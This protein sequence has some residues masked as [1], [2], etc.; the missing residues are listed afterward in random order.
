MAGEELTGASREAVVARLDLWT[1][2]HLAAVLAPLVALR[3]AEDIEGLARGIAFRLIENF[4]SLNR[5]DVAEDVRALDQA[6]RGQLR[7]YGVRFGG[8]SIF[9]PALLK[10]APARTLLI[11]WAMSRKDVA[12]AFADLPQPPT[13]GLTSVPADPAAPAGFYDALGFRVSGGRAVRLD[14]LERIADLIRPVI[15]ARHYNGGFIVTPAM[16][17]LVGCSGEEFSNLLKVLGYRS[18]VEKIKPPKIEEKPAEPAKFIVETKTSATETPAPASE[19][20]ATTEADAAPVEMPT[21]TPIAETAEA[22]TPAIEAAPEATAQAAEPTAETE[23]AAAPE[24]PT[25]DATAASAA[26]EAVEMVE[27]EI[28]RPQRRNKPDQQGQQQNRPR[29]ARRKPEGATAT[30]TEGQPVTGEAKADDAARR[31]RRD[32]N[33]GKFDKFGKADGTTEARPEG[34]RGEGH[35]GKRRDDRNKGGNRDDRNKGGNKGGERREWS[36]TPPR[37]ER[38]IDPDSP[39]AALAVLKERVEGK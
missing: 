37:R 36:S 16:M 24:A 5:E 23:T 4:G 29:R 8:Y 17:S 28:W 11:L 27:L 9:M 19:P 32:R 14:M 35:K 26:D 10:P 25:E 39:F 15:T 2:A 7:K 1:K 22:E 34:K 18:R 13:A 20:A 6:A 33:K 12:D 21:E 38:G 31:S 3:D 30:P